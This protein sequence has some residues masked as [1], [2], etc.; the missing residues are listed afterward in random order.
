[1][2]KLPEKSLAQYKALVLFDQQQAEAAA[3]VARQ[4]MEMWITT[5]AAALDVDLATHRFDL[6]LAAFVPRAD[7]IPAPAP[8]NGVSPEPPS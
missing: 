1:M 3:Q 7:T 6:A 8:D 2:L 5:T 4:R